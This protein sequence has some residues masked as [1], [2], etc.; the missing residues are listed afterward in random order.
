MAVV[1]EVV[2]SG[3]HG[4]RL[5]RILLRGR[6]LCSGRGVKAV[7][8][9]LSEKLCGVMMM[10]VGNDGGLVSVVL[11]CDQLDVLGDV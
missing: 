7:L 4:W 11:E 2:E 8:L 6:L 9:I 3:R 1:V 10:R 5:A